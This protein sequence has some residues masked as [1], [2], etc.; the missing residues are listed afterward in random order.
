MFLDVST[1]C[2]PSN[3]SD[4]KRRKELPMHSEWMR[5]IVAGI[6]LAQAVYWLL[7]KPRT[8][9]LDDEYYAACVH[10]GERK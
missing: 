7:L 5:L 2:I 9:S 6:V 10:P 1:A 3:I 4:V 8:D